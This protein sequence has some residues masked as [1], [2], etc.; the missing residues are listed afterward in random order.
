MHHDYEIFSA[1]EYVD[2]CRVALRLNDS[3]AE[4]FKGHLSLM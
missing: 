1:K 4:C 2:T 3:I